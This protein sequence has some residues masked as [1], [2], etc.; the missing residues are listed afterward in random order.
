MKLY[1]IIRKPPFMFRA[2]YW[3]RDDQPRIKSAPNSRHA[4]I[5][6]TLI[7]Q[8]GSLVAKFKAMNTV[9]PYIKTLISEM[10]KSY[11]SVKDKPLT[12]KTH[13]DDKTLKQAEALAKSLGVGH[14]GYAEVKPE[15]IFR[16]FEILYNKAMVI[17]M[18]MDHDD[19]KTNPSDA[20]SKEIF[21][22]YTELGVIVNKLAEFFEERGYRCEASPAIGGDV[23]T[24][25]LV[26]DAGLGVVG[27]HGLIITPEYGPSVRLAAV[28]LD[29]ENLP[30]TTLKD[31]PHLW[32]KDF[33]E[34]CNH[35]IDTCPGK[36][37]FRETKVL[38]DG[39]PLYIDKEKCA[40]EF[41]KNCSRCISTCPFFHGQYQK[42]KETFEQHQKEKATA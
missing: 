30:I 28:F 29:I 16:D 2:S 9:G 10:L 32:I 1:K 3:M 34:T 23:M 40:P 4:V 36:A 20:A 8:Y 31:N 35:C 12:G 13:I 7:A 19:M 27:K 24:V 39:F 33:C 17:T 25:P 26:Q 42:I 41:S 11:R 6:P 22:T 38:N 18:E 5:I 37:I 14:I 21:R 15:Y